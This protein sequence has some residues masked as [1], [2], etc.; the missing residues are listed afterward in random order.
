[1]TASTANGKRQAVVVVNI[2]S[3]VSWTRIEAA[4]TSALCSG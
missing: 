3:R 2:N 1:M 4:A